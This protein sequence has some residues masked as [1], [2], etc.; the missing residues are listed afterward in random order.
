MERTRPPLPRILLDIALKPRI[1]LHRGREGDWFDWRLALLFLVGLSAVEAA[2]WV[3]TGQS[4]GGN[5]LKVLYMGD[6]VPERLQLMNA[7]SPLMQFPALLGAKVGADLFIMGVTH[8]FARLSKAPRGTF[9]EWFAAYGY[10]LA[11]LDLY[12]IFATGIAILP[13]TRALAVSHILLAITLA[14]IMLV[15]TWAYAEVYGLDD[16][17]AYRNFFVFFLA[18]PVAFL[19]PAALLIP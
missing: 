19:A 14:W 3:A 13:G 9:K 15:Y 16:D 1:T 11:I 5:P 7:W 6:V 10:I 12:F 18:I 8:R 2:V 17:K 4:R